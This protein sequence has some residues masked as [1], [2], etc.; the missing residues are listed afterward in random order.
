MFSRQILEQLGG[1]DTRLG[2]KRDFLLSGEE[3]QMHHR[4]MDAGRNIY[5]HASARVH[6]LVEKKRV[7]TSYFYRR[8]YWGGITDFVM[9]KTL[10]GVISQISPEKTNGIQRL[11][12]LVAHSTQAVGLFGSENATIR[13]RI[14][15][16][17]VLGQMAGLLRYGRLKIDK[18]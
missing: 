5:Y 4:L 12:R 15:M 7:S 2:R 14:Y 18:D 9:A 16:S 3:V 8:Y 6:H 1:F 10:S 13:S 11:S 17:Y